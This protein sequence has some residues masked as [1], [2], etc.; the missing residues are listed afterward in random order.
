MTRPSS[1]P[2]SNPWK[3]Q[4][5]R[6]LVQLQLQAAGIQT[7]TARAY[8]KPSEAFSD[9]AVLRPDIDGVPGV[10]LDTAM[11]TFARLG[12]Y[13]DH[14]AFAAD[15]EGAGRVP[16]VALYRQQHP[17]SEAYAVLRLAD[18]ARLV[19]DAQPDREGPRP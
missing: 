5:W 1:S 12:T 14:A 18:L 8:R 6:E 19:Q 11:S 17:T 13:L 4:R 10:W 16:A 3:G 15:T 2:S 9:D 7:A